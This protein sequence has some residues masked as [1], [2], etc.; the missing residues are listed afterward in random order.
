LRQGEKAAAVVMFSAPIEHPH[1]SYPPTMPETP[2][3]SFFGP[4]LGRLILTPWRILRLRW[5]EYRLTFALGL[6]VPPEKRSE[7]VGTMLYRAEH[8]YTPKPY[9]GT[10]IC[11]HGSNL[12]EFGPD[13]GWEPF[14]TRLEHHVI[15]DGDFSC[16]RDLFYEP[17]VEQTARELNVCLDAAMGSEVSA[18]QTHS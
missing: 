13:L 4:R 15:G 7:Y 17:L 14:A 16:R 9:P 2:P 6:R 8:L 10:L 12:T 5:S 18:G 11:F 3:R 1:W